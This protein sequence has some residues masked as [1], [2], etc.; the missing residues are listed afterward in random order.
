MRNGFE[1]RK[2]LVILI[3]VCVTIVLAAALTVTLLLRAKEQHDRHSDR[4][5]ELLPIVTQ[6][7]SVSLRDMAAYRL[8]ANGSTEFNIFYYGDGSLF[9]RGATDPSLSC[10]R[11]GIR[12]TLRALYRAPGDDYAHLAGHYDGEREAPSLAEA[13]ADFL[14]TY[15]PAPTDYSLYLK[16]RLAILA[17]GAANEA[18][19]QSSAAPFGR[20]FA[21]DLETLL[22]TL[23][24]AAEPIDILLVVP[25]GE[26]ADSPRAA[27]I[28]ALA[29]HYGL[30]CVDM[31]ARLAEDGLLHTE[32]EDAGYP[33]D[34]GHAAYAAA[35]TD[36][37]TAAAHENRAPAPLPEERLYP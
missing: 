19:G 11:L 34:A 23:L 8:L 5:D 21:A 2:N 9:G 14:A 20:G 35:I 28:L 18:A 13:A 25:H 26:A 3:A 7:P 16:Y 12:S 10:Y 33:T 6:G 29:E 37:I 27:A 22:R 32:G 15:S 4:P 1:K 17:P 31:R 30:V 24:E 36:A